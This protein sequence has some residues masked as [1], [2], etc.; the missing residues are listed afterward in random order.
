MYIMNSNETATDSAG[1]QVHVSSYEVHEVYIIV[2]PTV[3][4][5]VRSKR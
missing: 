2:G 1:S 4:L 5:D 3:T